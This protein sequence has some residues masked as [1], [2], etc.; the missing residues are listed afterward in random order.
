MNCF[1]FISAPQKNGSKETNGE[2]K[3][4]SGYC[5]H[6]AGGAKQSFAP[7]NGLLRWQS[8]SVHWGSATWG[9]VCSNPGPHF[10]SVEG[11]HLQQFCFFHSSGISSFKMC[12]KTVFRVANCFTFLFQIDQKNGKIEAI[13]Y[14]FFTFYSKR[15]REKSVI[16]F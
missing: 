16:F 4:L 14:P 6:C 10:N 5:L 2:P 8:F 3:N 11:I 15:N 7:Q 12:S 9:G 13:R 1:Q